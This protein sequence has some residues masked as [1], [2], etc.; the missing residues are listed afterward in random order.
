MSGLNVF[1][2]S[3]T[4]T[5]NVHADL[6][7]VARATGGFLVSDTNDL[8]AAFE[9]IERDGSEFYTIAY[10]PTNRTYD[11]AFRKIKVMLD[12]K[13]YRLRFRQGYW[14]IPPGRE[15]LLTPG[16]A[17][18]LYSIQTGSKKS[19]F[20]PNLRAAF[21]Q[22]RD[23]RF[24]VPVA[25]SMPGSDVPFDKKKDH[26]SSYVTTLLLARDK[27]NKL[28]SVYERYGDL[29][30]AQKDWKAF[31]QT[32]FNMS[33]SMPV[34]SLEPITVQGIVQFANGEIGVSAQARLLADNP[35]SGLV[36]TSLVLSNRLEQAD[37]E[38]DATDPLCI[39]NLRV[40]FPARAAFKSSDHLVVYFS[41][42]NLAE[43]SS[44]QQ[45][46]LQVKFELLS[47]E[48]ISPL[49]PERI[50]SVPGESP[51]SLHVLGVFNLNSFASGNY[52]LRAKVAD[53]IGGKQVINEAPF[54]VSSPAIQ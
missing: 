50:Q 37:C 35:E 26:Y 30:F 6:G 39:K 49:N 27:D 33:G 1:D 15:V 21:V 12:S 45:P 14:A 11:G 25:L 4:L 42:L 13:G 20:A 40:Y 44:T 10:H 34:P 48:A 47:G 16:G 5:S 28:I 7:E 29:Q 31:Q 22:A 24:A 8:A 3:A 53:T 23:G 51:N 18:L 41:A 32:L 19:A 36:L 46:A 54:V 9:R 17:Q 43:A 38:A 52:K 2:W